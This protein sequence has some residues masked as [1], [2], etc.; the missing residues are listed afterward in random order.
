MKGSEAMQLI[1]EGHNN[2]NMINEVSPDYIHT[3]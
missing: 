3:L 2:D 1:L